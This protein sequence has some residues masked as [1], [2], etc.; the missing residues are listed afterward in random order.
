LTIDVSFGNVVSTVRRY[1]AIYQLN[2]YDDVDVEFV[3]LYFN[4]GAPTDGY[5]LYNGTWED[6]TLTADSSNAIEVDRTN[7][8]VTISGTTT[9]GNADW[10]RGTTGGA[11]ST[12]LERCEYDNSLFQESYGNT[13]PSS[14]V[15]VYSFVIV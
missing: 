8:S 13:V 3:E 4:E 1:E 2:R 9:C 6:L 15:N 11:A 7:A 10:A 5:Y 12:A 14:S